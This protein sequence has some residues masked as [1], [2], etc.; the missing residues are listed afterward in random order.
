[1]RRDESAKS[2]DRAMH[3]PFDHAELIGECTVAAAAIKCLDWGRADWLRSTLVELFESLGMRN[4]YIYADVLR[5]RFLEDY[6]WA[7]APLAAFDEV[8]TRCAGRCYEDWT[9]PE[10]RAELVELSRVAE[11]L[12]TA[13]EWLT[14]SLDEL[15]YALSGS[16][17]RRT[18]GY[19]LG[20]VET[21][22]I[23]FREVPAIGRGKYQLQCLNSGCHREARERLAELLAG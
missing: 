23:K 15:G 19:F 10:R 1:M 17:T 20:L 16:K 14:G 8:A 5:R 3:S 2:E 11:V 7:A 4:S 21:G 12:E 22:C 18:K 9:G 6:P 13:I